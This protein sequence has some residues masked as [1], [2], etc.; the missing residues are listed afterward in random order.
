MVTIFYPEMG[1]EA[2]YDTQITARCS[3]GRYGYYLTC[4]ADVPALVGRGIVPAGPNNKGQ[5]TYSVTQTAYPFRSS[6]N[7]HGSPR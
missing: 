4:R 1:Q 7:A 5:A 3:T 2:A 6:H